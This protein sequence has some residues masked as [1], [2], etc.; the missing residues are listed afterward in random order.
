MG[1]YQQSVLELSYSILQ[2]PK[3]KRLTIHTKAFKQSYVAQNLTPFRQDY[4]I[5]NQYTRVTKA[6]S[7]ANHIFWL[8]PHGALGLCQHIFPTMNKWV[9]TPFTGK[10]IKFENKYLRKPCSVCKHCQ[11]RPNIEIFGYEIITFLTR[12]LMLIIFGDNQWQ[13]LNE[14]LHTLPQKC[15]P[16]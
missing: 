3:S 15:W 13:G 9:Y 6:K 8:V 16:F 7:K 1:Y 14:I 5:P 12:L 2:P 4:H 11:G 10:Q